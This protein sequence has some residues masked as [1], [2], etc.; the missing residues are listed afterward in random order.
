MERARCRASAA[1]TVWSRTARS[2]RA[3]NR[4]RRGRCSPRARPRSP[5]PR[6]RR[7]RDPRARR[8]LARR[9]RRRGA[10]RCA[11]GGAGPPTRPWRGDGHRPALTPGLKSSL[12]AERLADELAFAAARLELLATAPP[13]P[14]AE[15]ADPAGDEEE[16]TWLA[17]LVA[18]L[19]PL[20][21]DAPFAAIESVRT[22][23]GAGPDLEGVEVGPRGSSRSRARH[24]DG[25]GLPR[26]GRACRAPRPAA[27][28]GDAS[29]TAERRFARAFERLALP[30]M[31]RDVRFGLLVTL[32][33]ALGRPGARGREGSSSG[34]TTRSPS[35]P[36]APSGSA[37]R[38][39]WS[40]APRRSAEAAGVPL[41]ALDLGLFNWER[42]SRTGDGVPA[43]GIGED[44]WRGAA[45]RALELP[46]EPAAD[47]V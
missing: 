22:A 11:A 42:R 14:L 40:G 15:I 28:A 25:R 36:S 32:L 27:Y 10:R 34:A 39:C 24:A 31:T 16:R 7:P 30:G 41:A 21:A 33:G 12:E 35:R 2:A 20:D 37:I 44:R 3:S 26:L 47:D 46:P 19:G 5:G 45:R 1:T 18:Y 38:C 43:A 9:A 4:W 29:W 17:F 6:G 23:W 8:R 13:G